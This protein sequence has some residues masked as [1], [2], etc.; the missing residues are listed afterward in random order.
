MQ[1]KKQP[2]VDCHIFSYSYQF[3]DNHQIITLHQ[4]FYFTKDIM[5]MLY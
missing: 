5:I 3:E 2:F 1:Q 4:S